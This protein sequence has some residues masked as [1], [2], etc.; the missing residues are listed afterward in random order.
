MGVRVV[1]LPKGG[2]KAA[3]S[4][5]F[6]EG[7]FVPASCVVRDGGTAAVFVVER[8]VV[9]KV[10]LTLGEPKNERYLVEKGL[11]GGEQL[12]VKPPARL[13]DGDHV[14]VKE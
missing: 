14:R 9:H 4:V 10:A 11:A 3:A 8:G 12:V 7:V 5:P 6:A 2:G 13:E 1:F